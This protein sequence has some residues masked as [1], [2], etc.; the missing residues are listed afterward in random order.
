M[1]FTT[2]DNYVDKPPAKMRTNLDDAYVFLF[3]VHV[4]IA[5]QMLVFSS[6]EWTPNL[7]QICAKLNS[8]ATVNWKAIIGNGDSS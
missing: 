4:A 5:P 7:I 1:R 8:K 3:A 6:S 2:P